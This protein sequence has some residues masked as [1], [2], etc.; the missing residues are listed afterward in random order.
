MYMYK[1]SHYKHKISAFHISYTIP[2]RNSYII[3]YT[4]DELRY[5]IHYTIEEQ[6]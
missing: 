4:I 3:Q 1:A 5:H 6:E 2:L